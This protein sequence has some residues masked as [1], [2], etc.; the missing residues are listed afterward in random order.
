MPP[1][2][3]NLATSGVHFCASAA[4][5]ARHGSR[6]APRPP[7]TPS[8]PRCSQFFNDFRHDFLT[9]FW[10]RCLQNVL[11]HFSGNS[12]M[13][14]VA[15]K[16]PPRFFPACVQELSHGT[17]RSRS[18]AIDAAWFSSAAAAQV[19]SSQ[20][21]QRWSGVHAQSSSP[22]A[23]EKNTER[24]KRSSLVSRLLGVDQWMNTARWVAM[25]AANHNT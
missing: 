20:W 12:V 3:S 7:K 13:Q 16:S 23:P 15:E 9:I 10:T 14:P 11:D 1:S 6:K 24:S 22:V 18:Q 5:P 19:R 8:R 25:A 2:W 17:P 4:K 21:R